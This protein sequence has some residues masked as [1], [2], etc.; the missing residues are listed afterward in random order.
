MGQAF[1]VRSKSMEVVKS[2]ILRAY[3]AQDDSE[4]VNVGWLSMSSADIANGNYTVLDLDEW[5]EMRKGPE[6]PS[7]S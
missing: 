3:E 2:G 6:G 7:R 1:P 4:V 5:F